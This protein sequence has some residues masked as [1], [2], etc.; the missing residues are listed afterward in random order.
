MTGPFLR[1]PGSAEGWDAHSGEPWLLPISDTNDV[2]A[3]T[4]A[5]AIAQAVRQASRPLWIAA[6]GLCLALGLLL[7][8][9]TATGW[10][11]PAAPQAS[12]VKAPIVATASAS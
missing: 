7:A 8:V 6:H 9:E 11:S 10:M 4:G 1:L 3:D 2:P 12:A 5:D